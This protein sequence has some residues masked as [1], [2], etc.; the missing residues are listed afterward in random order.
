VTGSPIDFLI[1]GIASRREMAIFTTDED[2]G[3]YAA[4]LPIKLHQPE[5][6]V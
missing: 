5:R 2:F 1:C 3:R 6:R 4:H